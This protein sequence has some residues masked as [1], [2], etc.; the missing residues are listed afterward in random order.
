MLRSHS[1]YPE[2]IALAWLRASSYEETHKISGLEHPVLFDDDS[3]RLPA[4]DDDL[5]RDEDRPDQSLF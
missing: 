1:L 3:G 5:A 2:A 4:T